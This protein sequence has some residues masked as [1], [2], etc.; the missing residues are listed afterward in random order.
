MTKSI[1]MFFFLMFRKKH[2]SRIDYK[3]IRNEFT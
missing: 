3:S 2:T 1:R